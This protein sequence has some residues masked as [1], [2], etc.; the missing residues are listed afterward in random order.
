[1]ETARSPG[2]LLSRAKQWPFFSYLCR[3][4][5]DKH[6]STSIKCHDSA[7][8]EV[9]CSANGRIR[10]HRPHWQSFLLTPL[11]STSTFARKSQ[12]TELSPL[13]VRLG[14][15]AIMLS[16]RGNSSCSLCAPQWRATNRLHREGVLTSR[17]STRRECARSEALRALPPRGPRVLEYS[18]RIVN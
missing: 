12:A 18:P 15:S 14:K 10:R 2:V 5:P 7:G 3:P 9:P 4:Y 13:A 16:T 1:M 11:W 6:S 8:R 17:H